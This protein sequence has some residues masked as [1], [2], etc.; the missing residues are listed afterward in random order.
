MASQD[1]PKPDFARNLRLIGHSDQGGRPDGVQLMVNKGFAYIGHM[2]SKGFSVVDVRDPRDPKPVSY[3]PAPPNT[4]NIHLQTHGDLLLVINAKDMFAAAEFQDEKA[5]YKGSLGKKVGTAEAN[6]NSGGRDWTAGM[7][8]YDISKPGEPRK[9]GF[10]PVEGGGVHRIWYTGGRWAYCSVLLDGFTDYIFMTIDM[11]DPA[12]PVPAGKWWIPGMNQAAGEAPDWAP[13]R[14]FGLHHPIVAGDIAYCAWRDAGMVVLDVADRHDPKLLV[15]RNWSPP[16][17][18]GTHNCLPLPDRDLLVVLDEA[19]L[20]NQEDGEKLIWIFDNRLPSNPISISTFKSP[21]EEDY[22][23]KGGHFGPHN[24]H[25]NRP[26]SY[27]SSERIFTTYQNA[28]VRV[29]DIK[30]Q[31]RPHEIAAFVPPKPAKLVDHRPGR[32]QVI[33]ACDIYV[34]TNGVIYANDYNGGLFILEYTGG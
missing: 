11:A 14:R 17:G 15:H 18:G 33:Q 6:P 26:D 10:M 16:F 21:D 31:Y 3:M 8:V 7:A 4:W 34:D 24:V 28:G 12:K 22:V 29:F 2:F 1:L 23:R 20:D 5:Y 25:E 13:T 30:D 27:V 32:P 19:V 9:I